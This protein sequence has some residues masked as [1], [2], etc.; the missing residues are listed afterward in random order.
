[1]KKIIQWLFAVILLFAFIIEGYTAVEDTIGGWSSSAGKPR[2]TVN[3]GHIL[4]SDN[5]TYNIGSA[6]YRVN[7]IHLENLNAGAVIFTPSN[8]DT[9]IDET[10]DEVN[11]TDLS[12]VRVAVASAITSAEGGLTGGSDGQICTIIIKSTS[13]GSWTLVD[14][15]TD[16]D[17]NLELAASATYNTLSANDTITFIKS[18]SYWYELSRS[19]N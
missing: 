13:I 15:G 16:S 12:I 1:M 6:N 9:T 18:G 2:W 19:N 3:S 11:V 5:D 7:E 4:P 8:T 14:R 10:T 17:S